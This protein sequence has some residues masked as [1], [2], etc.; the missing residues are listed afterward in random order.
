MPGYFEPQFYQDAVL[1]AFVES[2]LEAYEPAEVAILAL[3]SQFSPATAD[4]FFLTLIGED[5][6]ERRDGRTDGPYRTAVSA[7]IAV[8]R[9]RGTW[10]DI[11]TAIRL[12]SGSAGADVTAKEVGGSKGA[13]AYLEPHVNITGLDPLYINRAIQS[14]KP[15]GVRLHYVYWPAGESSLF[16]LASGSSVET[17]TDLGLADTGMTTGGQLVGAYDR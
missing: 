10:D 3:R 4:G 16:T 13:E 12:L 5:V 15:I 2:I 14:A 17:S 8:N 9:S 6:G 11:V 1:T 7:R